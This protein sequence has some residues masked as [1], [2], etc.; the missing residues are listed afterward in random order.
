MY[1]KCPLNRASRFAG[2]VAQGW[3][4]T[5]GSWVSPGLFS[6]QVWVLWTGLLSNQVWALWTQFSL[7]PAPGLSPRPWAA[8]GEHLNAQ[9]GCFGLFGLE[10][11]PAMLGADSGSAVAPGYIQG[12]MRCRRSNGVGCVQGNAFP[13]VLSL[14][15]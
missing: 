15:P 10:P 2:C 8:G 5:W 3:V 1:V 7:G 11:H 12:R 6:D 14:D 13:A 9:G 4:P